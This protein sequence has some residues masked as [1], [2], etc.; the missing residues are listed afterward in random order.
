M[1]EPIRLLAFAFAG[2]D[3]LFEINRDGIILF[4]SGAITGFSQNGDVTGINAVEF[5]TPT[6]QA[7][8]SIISR[9]LAKGQRVG[10]LPMTLASG[11]RG[12]LS[13]CFLPQSDRIAC[14]LV[15]PDQR[16]S[17]EREGMDFETGLADIGAFYK[18]V[19]QAAGGEG[20]I[21]LV[22]L[23]DL[24]KA[25]TQLTPEKNAALMAGIGESI[26]AIGATAAAR[27]SDTGFGVLSDNPNSAKE[28]AGRIKN[29]AADSGLENITAE[30]GTFALQGRNLSGAQTLLVLRHIVGRFADGKLDTVPG[31]D[32]GAVFETILSE[33]MTRAQELTD[34]V[35]AGAFN[36]VFEPIVDLK[37]GE[38][39]HYEAL[40][41]FK[42][43]ES[44]AEMI[45]FAEDL[46][47]SD[48]IDLAVAAK[49]F[50]VLERD[51]GITTSIAFNLSGRSISTPSICAM[52]TGLL[53]KKRKF[54]NRIFIEITETSEMP[55]LAAA[56]KAIQDL[57][58][59][60][61][62][63][64]IDDFGAGAASLQYLH[65]LNVD[66][67]KIDGS[68]IKRTGTSPRD[69]SLLKGIISSCAGSRIQTIAEWID[70]AEKLKH[71]VELGFNLGQGR[72]FGPSLKT[73]PRDK[74]F[75]PR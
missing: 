60:G 7:R 70:S 65:A 8:F 23:P 51:P 40:T 28:L 68:L 49:V 46:G 26:K 75:A 44:P 53:N 69:D 4:A 43:G 36:L 20:A 41:R 31:D 66:F 21:T 10:P 55:D 22:D 39:H 6:E 57:R 67:I 18:A 63:V 29:A 73:P 58:K 54:A 35:A 59:L 15:K 42:A 1:I 14:T 38:V 74:K 32:L 19:E 47:L 62:K 72:H 13:M 50:R 17:P 71:C 25:R 5:F 56:D 11:E 16:R 33:T 27:L 2:A 3:L 24:A 64:G 34:R 52:M 9:G 12:L 45:R 30:E 61:Y 48:S 37:T